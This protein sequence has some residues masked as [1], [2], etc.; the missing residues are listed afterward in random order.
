MLKHEAIMLASA[1]VLA[2]FSLGLAFNARQTSHGSRNEC[3]CECD[4]NKAS[5]EAGIGYGL[6]MSPSGKLQFGLQF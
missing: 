1:V 6:N 5:D 4:S 3:D 2:M